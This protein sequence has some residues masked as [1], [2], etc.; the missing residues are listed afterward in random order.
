VN[1]QT[2]H[3]APKQPRKVEAPKGERLRQ[4]G[5]I[6]VAMAITVGVVAWLIGLDFFGVLFP[7]DDPFTSCDLSDPACFP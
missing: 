6:A 2:K 5:L 7:G 1:R 4:A 3:L